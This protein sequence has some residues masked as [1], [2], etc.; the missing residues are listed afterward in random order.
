[1][2][3]LFGLVLAA[4]A[5]AYAAPAFADREAPASGGAPSGACTAPAWSA[6]GVYVGGS[7]VTYDG[8]EYTAAYWNQGSEPDTNSGAAGSGKPWSSP[9]PCGGPT[10][11]TP[12]CGGMQCGSDGCG[13]TCGT[14]A[15]GETCNA[16][17]QCVEACLPSCELKQC[18][19]DGCGGSCGTCAAGLTCN[20]GNQCVAPCVPACSGKQ[21]GGDTCGGSCGT[22]P[23]GETCTSSG[24]CQSATTTSCSAPPWSANASYSSGNTV[25]YGNSEY[26]AAFWNQGSEPDQNDGPQYSGKPW[27]MPVACGQA[28]CSPSCAGKACG[29]DG[30]GGSCG[31]CASGETCTSSGACQDTAPPPSGLDV[32]LYPQIESNWCWAA[33]GEMVMTF[34]GAPVEQCAEANDL[35]GRTDCCTSAT[36]EANACNVTGWPDWTFWGFKYSATTDGTALT[37]AQLQAEIAARR[38]VGFSWHWSSGGG[39][40]MVAIG[41]EVDE[42]G[43]EWVTVNDPWSPNVGEQVVLTYEDYV[44][45]P[46]GV[47]ATATTSYT[48][49]LDQYGIAKN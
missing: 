4:G 18:G 8:N 49:W 17:N 37:F 35:A 21:C 29:D 48:H 13:G 34:L 28:A 20:L 42:N 10:T 1:M 31:T 32:T 16:S 44:S 25:S 22:C 38:P 2:H 26:T 9:V 12:S 33:S 41:A 11:C 5:T 39:H 45:G 7:T 27:L 24:S 6:S 46:A 40:Y 36:S 14:C 15:T 43:V 23:T 30:C 47:D 19:N 3:R